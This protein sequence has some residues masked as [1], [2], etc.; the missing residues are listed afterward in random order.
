MLEIRL[1][2]LSKKFGSTRILKDFSHTFRDSSPCHIEGPNGS[3]KS[4]LLK[5]IA[6]FTTP[7]QGSIQWMHN[8]K[9]LTAP[10]I[11]SLLSYAAPYIDVPEEFTLTELLNFHTKFRPFQNNLTPEYLIDRAGLTKS[12]DKTV[13][14]F[15]SGMKQRVK[16]GLAI[17]A[18][19]P[20]LLLDEPVSNLDKAGKDFYAGLINDFG[21]NRM[22]IVCSNQIP[23]E[24]FFCTDKVSL[25][26]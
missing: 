3:G 13:R 8:D 23:E 10:E 22:I 6:G 20:L 4:S 14:S 15:S 17:L 16:L 26:L 2:N 5:I 11:W 25:G 19:T 12:K 24:H 21:K 18:D 9:S 1:Q 7:D